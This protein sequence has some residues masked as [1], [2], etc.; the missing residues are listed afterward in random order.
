MGWRLDL[1]WQLWGVMPRVA[2]GVYLTW[3]VNSL[4]HPGGARRFNTLDDS[5]NHGWVALL[6]GGEGWRNDH[7]AHPVSAAHRM[8]WREVDVN[9]RGIRLRALLGLG[10]KYQSDASQRGA[11]SGNGSSLRRC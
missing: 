7:Q 5:T 9:Y 6:T 11:Q 8:G 3:L 2:I 4:T 10:E 1:S